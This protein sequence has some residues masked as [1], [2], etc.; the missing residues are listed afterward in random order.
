MESNQ[1]LFIEDD[2]SIRE[3]VKILLEGD[4]YQV[5]EA[6]DGETGLKCLTQETDLVILDIMMP[7]MSGITT[8]K[9]IRKI[10]TVPVL[11]LTAKRME[12]DKLIGLMA[13]GDDYLVKPFSHA[14][15][16][17]RVKALIRRRLVYDRLGET[18]QDASEWI[19]SKGLCINKKH[20]ELRKD[21]TNIEL[22]EME[23][24]ILLLLMSHPGKIFS[25]SNI[26]E[27]LW[28]EPFYYSSGNTVMV[29][30]RRLR[31]K[32][33]SDPQQPVLVRTVWGKGYSF[34]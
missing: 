2:E 30:I 21:G 4:G 33:E 3:G 29:H 13:G 18:D 26:Y 20:N 14:E 1:I 12:S 32:I 5:L 27:S 10:S 9:E 25:V 22:T 7:G 19:E 6:P 15:L 34:G 24:Q 16:L 11:F 23:Y 28:D 17:M 8:C 31:K